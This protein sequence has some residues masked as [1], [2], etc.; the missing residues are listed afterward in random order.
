MQDVLDQL[1]R[2]DVLPANT[3]TPEQARELP[4][5]ADAVMG[6]L[7]H[8]MSKRVLSLAMPVPMP[9]GKIEHRL[10]PSPQGNV[11]VRV[12][13][14]EG[15]GPFP[16]LVYFHGGGWVIANLDAYDASCR[17]LTNQAHCIVVSV[18]YRKAPEYKYPAAVQDAYAATQW[19]MA[20]AALLNGDTSHVAIA[21]ESAGGNLAAAVALMARDQGALLPIH[22]LLVYPVTNYAFDTPSYIENVNAKPLSRDMMIWFWNNYLSDASDGLNPYA[23]PLRAADLSG[24]PPATII[25]AEIDPLRSEGH[26]Y[27]QRL[28]ETGV[29]VS[30]TCYEG[31][32]HEF[33]GMGAVVPKAKQA[34]SEAVE[35][36][37][38]V[39]SDPSVL[40]SPSV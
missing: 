6:V 14:P 16:V 29:P 20:N 7:A 37:Q 1:V 26:A 21:G 38:A 36:L 25:G 19:V 2:L 22:Q 8:Q 39:L 10:I 18:A 30:Y 34:M 4:T 27:A 33:F 23:S 5:P 9:V 17:S 11:L 40:R 28:Q 12:Y 13:T 15:T 35:R 31:V 32:T 24:L 3:V